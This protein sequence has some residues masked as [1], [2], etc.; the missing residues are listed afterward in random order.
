[1]PRLAQELTPIERYILRCVAVHTWAHECAIPFVAPNTHQYAVALGLAAPGIPLLMVVVSP[2]SLQQSFR[3]TRLGRYVVQRLFHLVPAD[4]DQRRELEFTKM[5]RLM[6]N[7]W[8]PR[9]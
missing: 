7:A 5:R 1:L 2:G 8:E 3:L 9:E 4:D 6:Q